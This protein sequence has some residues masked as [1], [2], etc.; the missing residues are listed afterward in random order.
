MTT[1]AAITSTIFGARAASAEEHAVAPEARILGFLRPDRSRAPKPAPPRVSACPV[2]FLGRADAA[3]PPHRARPS[4]WLATAVAIL[5]FSPAAARADEH[6]ACVN[7][8]TT[9][10]ELDACPPPDKP[11]EVMVLAKPPARSASDWEADTQTIHTAPHQSGA[12]AIAV[13]PGLFVSDRGLPG[14]APHLSLRGF[15]GTSGQDVEIYVGNIPMNQTSHLRAPG[16]S[17]S[18][19]SMAVTA[20]PDG[21]RLLAKITRVFWM[22]R[23]RRG[24]GVR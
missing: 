5:S 7:K 3:R 17:R 4:R 15:D 18:V 9:Q 23:P 20:G 21:T 12:D 10:A 22:A 1:S 14:R 11:I 24:C 19:C 16:Q 6:Q 8:A 2:S 13:V